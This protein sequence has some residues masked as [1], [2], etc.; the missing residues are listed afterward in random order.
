M[1]AS[2]FRAT[3]VTRGLP[4]IPARAIDVVIAVALPLPRLADPL[5]A[6]TLAAIAVLVVPLL[7]SAP[8]FWRR[9]RPWTVLLAV[10]AAYL[11]A[12][13]NDPELHVRGLALGFACYAVARYSPA[14]ASLG[15]VGVA[16]GVLFVPDAVALAFG[17]PYRGIGLEPTAVLGVGAMACCVWLLGASL[18]RMS[19]DRD[20]LRELAERLAAEREINARHAVAAERTRLA[21]ELHDLVAHHVSA[22][23][24]HARATSQVYAD[25]PETVRTNIGDIERTADT[26][27]TEMRRVLRLLTD[28]R[29]A[30]AEPAPEPS[31]E[32]LDRL[33]G[34]VEA[35]GCRLEVTAE[36]LA[37]PVPPGVSLCAYRIV[38]EA[39]T[40]VVHHAGATEVRIELRRTGGELAITVE[41][42]PPVAGHGPRPGSGLGLVG[43]RQRAELFDA[44]LHAGP[45]PDGGWRVATRLRFAEPT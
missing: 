8:L 2:S 36:G 41:N 33:L 19:R 18:G 26:A 37:T 34:R 38:Q 28:E 16:T 45:T 43:M 23:A 30:T 27:L 42:G 3:R 40:N 31:L 5:P 11:P 17:L 32:H 6:P 44:A 4:A 29:P 22:I 39:L 24:L 9:S 10:A 1:T 13:L 7:E 21:H 20:R 14:P 12:E 25:D 15:A 35:A